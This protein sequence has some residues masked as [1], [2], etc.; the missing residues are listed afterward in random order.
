MR[1]RM[2][3]RLVA[4]ATGLTLVAWAPASLLCPQD[5]AGTSHAAHGASAPAAEHAHDAHGAPSSDEAPADSPD[6]PLAFVAGC[7]PSVLASSVARVTAPIP[8]IAAEPDWLVAAESDLHD[9][10]SIFHP[11]IG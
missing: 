4:V 1:N 10:H 11:P 5:G 6:C 2:L 3:R 9:T 7:I 8:E